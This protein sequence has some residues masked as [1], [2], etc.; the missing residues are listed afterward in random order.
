VDFHLGPIFELIV[1]LALLA[2]AG[3]VIT[4]V[5]KRNAKRRW[6]RL[7]S[8]RIERYIAHI[9]KIK[10]AEEPYSAPDDK[11]GFECLLKEADQGSTDALYALGRMYLTGRYLSGFWLQPDTSKAMMYMRHAANRGHVRATNYLE[12]QALQ[13]QQQMRRLQRGHSSI[14]FRSIST[15]LKNHLLGILLLSILGSV[16]ASYIYEYVHNKTQADEY[17]V[18]QVR[19]LLQWLVAR[20]RQLLP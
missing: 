5:N 10:N 12:E 9:G 16:V 2:V 1:A 14:T 13:E 7:E 4:I 18:D 3:L 11:A 6:M 8:A 19:L 15:F 20:S 17:V